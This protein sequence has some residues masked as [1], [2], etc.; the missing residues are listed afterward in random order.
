[1]SNGIVRARS[2]TLVQ[3]AIPEA[4]FGFQA[5]LLGSITSHSLVRDMLVSWHSSCLNHPHVRVTK[6]R[7]TSVSYHT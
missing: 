7:I 1:M 6:S 2:H 4:S 3:P 5:Q